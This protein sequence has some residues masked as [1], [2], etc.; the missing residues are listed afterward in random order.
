MVERDVSRQEVKEVILRGEQIE[1]YANDWPL[2]S[3]LFHLAEPNR[4]PLHVVNVVLIG[5]PTA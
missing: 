3:A 2:P 1:N 4:R 5:S